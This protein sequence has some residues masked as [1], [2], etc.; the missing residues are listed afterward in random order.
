MEDIL[1]RYIKKEKPA[2]KISRLKVFLIQHKF[3]FF[4]T[5]LSENFIFFVFHVSELY[6]LHPDM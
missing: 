4:D 1:N 3:F 6:A 5:T 2:G